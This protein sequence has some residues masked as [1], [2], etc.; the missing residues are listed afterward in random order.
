MNPFAA[1]QTV[2]KPLVARFA[3]RPV[4]ILFVLCLV[5]GLAAV[6]WR[7][8]AGADAGRAHARI[9]AQ[10]RGAAVELQLNQALT[11]AEVLGSLARQSGGGISNFQT[12]ALELLASRPGLASLE[13]QPG[14]V[15]SDVVPRAGHE[16]AIGFNVLKDAAHRPGAYAAIQRRVLTVTG[17]LTI[18]HGEPGIVVRVPVFQRGRDGRD[19]FWG[20]VAVSMRLP[21]ALARARVD[22]LSTQ[23]YHYA[24]FTPGSAQQKGVTIAARGAL[25]FQD[26]VQQPVRAQNLEFRLALRPRGGWVNATKVALEA[27]GVLVVSGLL[28]LLANLL[29]SRRLA[30]ETAEPGQTQKDRSGAKAGAAAAQAEFTLAELQERLDGTARRASETKEIAQTKLKQAELSARELQTRLDATVR[31]AAEAAQAK[32]AE[33]Q[34]ARLAL[35]Q[36]Q[37]A[38]NELQARVESSAGAEGKT[39]AAAQ[40]RLQHQ[41]TIAELQARLDAAKRSATEAAEASAARL[42]QSEK[43][44]RELAGRLLKAET[45]VTELS[46]LLQK[47]QADLKRLQNDSARSAGVR[48][49]APVDPLPSGPKET[50]GGEAVVSPVELA[51]A[52]SPAIAVLAAPVEQTVATELG[53]VPSES[54]G[55]PLAATPA[56]L[57]VPPATTNSK[58]NSS[59]HA[60]SD[61]VL[62]EAGALTSLPRAKRKSASRIAKREKVRRDDQI[63]LFEGQREAGQTPA[64]PNANSR[65]AASAEDSGR[66]ALELVPTSAASAPQELEEPAEGPVNQVTAPPDASESTAPRPQ[67]EPQAA[68][69]GMENHSATT[70]APLDL[71]V[72]EGLAAADGLA[73]VGAD[74]KVYFKALQHFVEQHAGAPEKIREALLQGDL[75]A[76][77]RMVRSLK[78]S[79]GDIGAS[80]VESAAAALSRAV[81]EQPD[82]GEIES[83]W[84]ELEK[85]VRDLVADLKPVLKPK[86]GKRAPARRL[87]APPPVNPA[88]L[89]K[90]VNE[91]LPLLADQDPGAK[92]CL[93][94]NRATFRSAFAPEACEKFEQFVKRGDFGT[95]LEQLK[96]AAKKYGISL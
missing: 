48:T 63:D 70:A 27:L 58:V 74:P 10:A 31:E 69:A 61:E 42:N 30:F 62:A 5:L 44:N 21:E 49:A 38:I 67:S 87:P 11:A 91:I 60:R 75:A 20:F 47:A 24:F 77:E 53:P 15:V 28:C 23:G 32:Q 89:R 56:P 73:R 68:S 37:Q 83:R 59:A 39:A 45:R 17:P 7:A 81:R 29:Q 46:A 16:R 26:A 9:A 54:Q 2:S 90:A 4:L 82:P 86:E 92:D 78:T 84:E 18:D 6:V 36:A 1:F 65:A 76:A 55:E 40:A 43:R 50:G 88:Q 80:A 14:G 19:Y 57:A 95:A 33:L 66:P 52:S 34:Q 12:V 93:K 85:V 51:V 72:I 71:P 13:L 79:A 94:A 96:K 3:A 22:E 41:A 35:A 64:N 25:S 8:K